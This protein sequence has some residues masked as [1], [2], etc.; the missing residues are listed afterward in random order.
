VVKKKSPVILLTFVFIGI[1]INTRLHPVDPQEAAK[2]RENQAIQS[3]PQ[4]GTKRAPDKTA[5]LQAA[6]KGSLG[7][8]GATPGKPGMAQAEGPPGTNGSLMKMKKPEPYKP[9]PNPSN[10]GAQWYR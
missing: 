7:S 3:M 5:D 9:V 6:M 1:A 2:E 8:K 10:T 4:Q